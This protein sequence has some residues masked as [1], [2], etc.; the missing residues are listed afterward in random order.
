[1]KPR[2][3][4]WVTLACYLGIG[5]MATASVPTVARGGGDTCQPE[6]KLHYTTTEAQMK[7]TLGAADCPREVAGDKL[8]LALRVRRCDVLGCDVARE[9]ASCMLGKDCTKVLTVHHGLMECAEY[10]GRVRYWSDGAEVIAGSSAVQARCASAGA[11]A[12]CV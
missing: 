9:R 11:T 4:T 2:S 10:V 7:V 1:M 3:L 5:M 6:A 12:T 8:H